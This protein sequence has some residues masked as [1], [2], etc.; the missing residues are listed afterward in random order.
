ME[1]M[2]AFSV[3]SM[4]TRRK[5]L[6]LYCKSNLQTFSFICCAV[7]NFILL[8]KVYC[9]KI[10]IKEIR[11]DFHRF[12]NSGQDKDH[13]DERRQTLAKY[14]FFKASYFLSLSPNCAIENVAIGMF[15]FLIHLLNAYK[16]EI[17]IVFIR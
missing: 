4:L 15:T 12:I 10:I 11:V 7:S 6:L 13:L 8:L 2:E 16:N 3:K 9:K 14:Y 17:S 1:V 5:A